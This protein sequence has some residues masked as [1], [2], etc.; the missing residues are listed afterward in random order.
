MRRTPRSLGRAHRRS[1]Q[2]GL[3]LAC[4]CLEAQAIET[5]VTGR[6]TF[7]TVMRMEAADPNL[8]TALNAP[9]VG[10][11]GYASGSN[12]DD[13]NLNFRRHDAASTALKAYVASRAGAMLPSRTMSGSGAMHPMAT[14]RAHR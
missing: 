10:L 1:R 7:G 2:A 9:V 12:A 3:V 5:T 11:T 6:V 13:A 8:L 14:R 4:L